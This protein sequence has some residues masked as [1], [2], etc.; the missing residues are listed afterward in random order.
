MLNKIGSGSY[1]D[2]YKA[3]DTKKKVYRAVK[4]FKNNFK[5]VKQ[6][7]KE[8][9]VKVMTKVKHQNIIP[10]KKVIYE[11][12]KL[13][14]V[15][16]LCNKNLTE[17][18]EERYQSGR[19]F[20][21]NEIRAYMRD[22]ISAVQCLHKNGFLH[23]DLKPENILVSQ[24]NTLKLTDFGTIKCLKDKGPYTNYVST[25]WYRPPECILEVDKYDE[26]SDVFSLGCVFAEFFKLRPVFA[27]SSSKDQIMKYLSAVGI[28]Q[29]INWEKGYKLSSK[30]W[31][32]N[33]KF[34][35]P[36]L[37]TLLTG[38]SKS[39]SRLIESMLNINPLDRPTL[40]QVVSDE[41]F[42]QKTPESNLSY[43]TND[44][45]DNEIIL[46]ELKSI[47]ESQQVIKPNYETAE[48]ENPKART[49]KKKLVLAQD[50]IKKRLMNKIG[51]LNNLDL[52]NVVETDQESVGENTPA[53]K[54]KNSIVK[55]WSKFEASAKQ[56]REKVYPPTLVPRIND[57]RGSRRNSVMMS[58]YKSNDAPVTLEKYNSQ[59]TLPLLNFNNKMNTHDHYDSASSSPQSIFKNEFAKI[60]SANRDAP[61]PN[62]AYSSEDEL[63]LLQK[64]MSLKPTISLPSNK[65]NLEPIQK[66]YSSR[67]S[68]RLNNHP[69]G[70]NNVDKY[71]IDM[72]GKSLISSLNVSNEVFNSITNLN[73]N[74]LH[75]NSVSGSQTNRGLNAANQILFGSLGGTIPAYK[76]RSDNVSARQSILRTRQSGKFII[77]LV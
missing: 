68:V 3:Y 27:G 63:D 66:K 47:S 44:S 26:S 46:N 40:K 65:K 28:E 57:S 29:L 34:G 42:T 74:P 51:H 72:S 19:G 52:S 39:A 5:S 10:L 2:V 55:R 12:N 35:K 60:S 24:E 25:R 32:Q 11:D 61:F 69:S 59:S 22:L 7:M 56:N 31:L 48:N 18:M 73:K 43:S 4:K 49:G 77:Q 53:T 67:N 9:E 62:S 21:E 16:E 54:R 1:G 14:L 36:N 45:L 30:Y 6:C 41:F 20:T 23:R 33:E 76:L 38:A 37:H 64:Q 17:L 8:P 50:A 15:M 70:T 13:Y 71:F 58:K 75:R